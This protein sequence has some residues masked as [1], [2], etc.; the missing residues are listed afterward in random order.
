MP[1]D[2]ETL[3]LQVLEELGPA[4]G[5]LVRTYEADPARAEDLLQEI[6]LAI[7]QALPRW[8]KRSSLRTFVFRIAHNRGATHGWREGRRATHPLESA[9]ESIDPE[10]TI[11]SRLEQEQ[12]RERLF[13]AVAELP[14]SL[15]LA[16]SLKL[17]GLSGTEIAEVLGLRPGAVRARLHRAQKLLSRRVPTASNPSPSAGAPR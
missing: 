3:L 10:P 5:R 4:L 12:R 9:P 8:Q 2:R 16:V 14:L 15:R 7:W 13:A 11:D 17:E 1:D 6:C